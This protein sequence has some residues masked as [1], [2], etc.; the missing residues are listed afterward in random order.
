[1]C[2]LILQYTCPLSYYYTQVLYYI[3][4]VLTLVYMCPHTAI[5]VSSYSYS[6][7]ISR[8]LT[9]VYMPEDKARASRV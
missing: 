1:M 2:V 9:L 7:Y 5:Y 3:P 4:R 8:V 6:C